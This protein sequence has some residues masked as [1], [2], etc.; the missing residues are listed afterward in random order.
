VVLTTHPLLAPRSRKSRAIPLPPLWAFGS[1]TE[2]LYLYTALSFQVRRLLVPHALPTILIHATF[3]AILKPPWSGEIQWSDFSFLCPSRLAN[4]MIRL[5]RI[6]ELCGSYLGEDTA[7]PD[8]DIPWFSLGLP[9][10][11]PK[12]CLRLASTNSLFNNCP[13]NSHYTGWFREKNK[14]F[15]RR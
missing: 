4:A 8:E 3:S 13:I 7:H 6:W 5:I 10:K 9:G 2:Y 14:Y 1:V 11:I 15:G 12:L